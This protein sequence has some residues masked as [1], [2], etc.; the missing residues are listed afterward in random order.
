MQRRFFTTTLL[1]TTMLA[2]AASE[3]LAQDFPT[4]PVRVIVPTQQGGSTDNIARLFQEAIQRGGH[5]AQPMVVANVTGAG[6]TVGTRQVKDADPDGYTLGVWHTGL[7]TARAME[8]TEYDHDG[9]EVI[10][11]TGSIPMGLAVREG[12]PFATIEDLVEAAKASPNEIRMATNIGLT[13][14][15]VPLIFQD[16]AGIEFRYVQTGGGSRR[17]QSVLGEHTDVALFSTQEFLN[18]APSGLK[19]IVLFAEE[20]HPKLPDLPT[21]QEIGYDVAWDEV[22]LWLAPVGTPDDVVD[23]LGDALEAAFND[24]RVQTTFE[25]QAMNTDFKRREEATAMLDELRVRATA[26]AGDIGALEEDTLPQ[27]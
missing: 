25:E 2:A 24:E 26:V 23:T 21:A 4:Q 10:A 20:R 14:H 11:Q 9:F 22:F 27:N 7:V 3:S 17:L 12:G 13:V 1:A 18:Y 15:F 16:A 8:V 19:P 5:L 6:G